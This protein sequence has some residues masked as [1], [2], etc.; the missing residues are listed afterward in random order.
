MN[1]VESINEMRNWK[2]SALDPEQ[3]DDRP[4]GQAQCRDLGASS[5]RG[6]NTRPRCF[7]LNVPHLGFSVEE[8]VGSLKEFGNDLK[9]D[10]A[11][12]SGGLIRF[13]VGY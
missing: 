5:M 10:L 3:G 4:S 11:G 2:F 8:P 9:E 12:G 6:T 7:T 1:K 13:V